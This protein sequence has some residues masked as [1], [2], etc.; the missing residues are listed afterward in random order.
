ML[1]WGKGLSLAMSLHDNPGKQVT[2]RNRVGAAGGGA[3][4]RDLAAAGRGSA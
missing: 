4:G 1:L 3:G 2:H